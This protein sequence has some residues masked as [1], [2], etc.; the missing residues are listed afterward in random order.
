MGGGAWPF[1]VGGAICLVNS[2]N[3]RDSSLL[4]R[5]KSTPRPPGAWCTR[6]PRAGMKSWSRSITATGSPPAT[7]TCRK[8]WSRKARRIDQG[9]VLGRLGSTGRSTGTLLHYE[10]RVDG[11]PVNPE[12][13]LRAGADVAASPGGTP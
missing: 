3:E 11:E 6:D 1:L 13:F 8:R 9:A 10:V 7:R 2:D 12:R 4:N 5:P